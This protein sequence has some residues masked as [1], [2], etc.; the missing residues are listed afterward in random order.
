MQQVLEARKRVLRKE[1]LDLLTAMA[2]LARLYA[3]Q[4]R[5]EDAA[6]LVVQTL[7]MRRKV[8]RLKYRDTLAS[9]ADFAGLYIQISLSDQE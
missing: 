3:M 4:S 6:T 1:D 5:Y 8:L 7:N 2:D 9:T